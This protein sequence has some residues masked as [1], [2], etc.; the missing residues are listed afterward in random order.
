MMGRM[1]VASALAFG[2][3]LTA[4]QTGDVFISP[5]LNARVIDG[6]TGT[7][8]DKVN[9]TMWST[10]DLSARQVGISDDTGT[11]MLPRLV[12]RLDIAFPFMGDR[13]IPPPTMARFEKPGYMPKEIN[14][15]A[16][17]TNFGGEKPIELEPSPIA[18]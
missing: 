15:D 11:V 8:L 3:F 6:R 10:E 9:V 2:L 7:P 4:C 1:R 16:D 13:V 17:R 14:S 12:G 5:P 18:K